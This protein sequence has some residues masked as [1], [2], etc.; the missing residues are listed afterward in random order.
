MG[1]ED[2]LDS[3]PAAPGVYLMK[4]KSGD[5]LYVGKAKSLRARVVSYFRPSGDSRYSVKFLAS[6]VA[7]IDWIIT[8]NEKEALFLEDT[9]LKKYKPRYN[10]RLK[11]SKTYCSIKI[12]AYA[13]FP[14]ILVTREIKKDGGLYFGPY[15]STRAVRDTVKFLRRIFP[16]CVCSESVFRNRVRPCLDYQL[17]LCAAPAVGHITEDGYRELVKG[18]VL[19]LQGKNKEL[20][21]LLKGK[22]RSA[23]GR[24]DFEEAARLRDRIAAIK[25]MLEEQKAVTHKP[26]DRD[27]FA[28]AKEDGASVIQALF[29]RDGR[30]VGGGSYF[31][32][33]AGLPDDEAISSFLARFYMGERYVPDEVIVPLQIEDA[34]FL[35]EWLSEKKGR[36]AG[37]FAPLRGEKLKLLKMAEE[38]ARESLK[39]K[40]DASVSRATVI[41][42]LQGRL[43]LVNLPNTIEAFD[44]SNI[45]GSMAVGAMAVFKNG[46]PNRDSYRRYRIGVEG[47]DDYAMMREVLERRYRGGQE[48]GVPDLILVDGGKGQLNIACRVLR[49]LG[50]K[51]VDVAALAKDRPVEGAGANRFIKTKGERVFR[52]NVKD[53]VAL[54][55]NSRPDLLIR[56]IRDTV[57]RLAVTYHRRLRSKAISSVLDTIPG[58]GVKTRK[59]LFER[60]GDI[61]G[62]QD[63]SVEELTS[64][65]GVSTEMAALIKGL[66]AGGKDNSK[67]IKT[68]N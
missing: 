39:K 38:N 53:P 23:S 9:L 32:E 56:M 59:A 28:A 45:G 40:R 21:K 29:V 7:D 8:A 16:L 55:E 42:E 67:L 10:I 19:F 12:T 25:E 57:H 36:K 47:P 43:H 3:L 60:F 31:F 68:K 52:P 4:G 63:A 22:M 5:V 46:E 13:K 58:I 33:E 34:A 20:L 61:P 18:A 49:E 17:G 1:I 37:I 35:S 6:R 62:M 54:K 65:A 41:S 11:D 48:A 27:V 51:G 15:V 44:I 50:I 24:L 14:R 30:L 2:K 66:K 26:I 64:V